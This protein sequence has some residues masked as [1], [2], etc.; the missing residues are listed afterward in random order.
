MAIR[1]KTKRRLIILL[2]ALFLIVGAGATFYYVRIG[3]RRAEAEQQRMKG[4]AAVEAGDYRTG[5]DLLGR[6]IGFTGGQDPQVLYLYAKARREVPMDQG[7][8]IFDAIGVLQRLRVME[9]DNEQAQRDLLELYGMVGYNTEAIELAD[10]LLQEYPNDPDALHAKA[11]AL[12]RQRQF[13]KALPLAQRFNELKPEDLEGQLL[14]INIMRSLEQPDEQIIEHARQLLQSHP[15]HPHFELVAG[16]AFQAVDQLQQAIRHYKNAA[17]YDH[18]G[19]DMVVWLV[20]RL[21]SVGL[22]VESRDLLAQYAPETENAILRHAWARR[23]WESRQVSDLVDYLAALDPQDKG[24]NAELIALR[25]LGHIRLDQKDAADRDIDALA[26]REK[27]DHARAWAMVLAQMLTPDEV[28]PQ[29]RVETRH[30]AAT[31]ASG[32]PYLQYFLGEA[33]ARIGERELAMDRWIQASQHSPGWPLPLIRAAEMMIT[34]GQPRNAVPLVRAALNRAPNDVVVASAAA[35]A[36]AATLAPEDETGRESILDLISQIQEAVPGEPRTLP[37]KVAL[38]AGAGQTDQARQVLDEALAADHPY[39]QSTLLRLADL[40]RRHDL[41]MEKQ[42]LAAAQEKHGSTAQLAFTRARELF[43]QGKPSEGLTSLRQARQAS[44]SPDKIDWLAAEAQYLELIG[45]PRATQAWVALGDQAPRNVNAQRAVLASNAAWQ[46]RQ[47]IDRSI[48]RLHELLGEE[49][50]TWRVAR[51]RWLISSDSEDADIARA[52]DLLNEV[53]NSSP[54]LTEPRLL[55]A[56]AHERRGNLSSAIEQLM[57]VMES[58][59]NPSRQLLLQLA[60]LRQQQGEYDQA[61]Q[62]IQQVAGDPQA[63]EADLHATALLLAQQGQPAAAIELL[64]QAPDNQND[65]HAMELLLAR[66]YMQSSQFDKAEQL[67]QRLL[68]EAPTMGVIEFAAD[69]YARH[70]ETDKAEALLDRLGELPDIAPATAALVR[71]GYYA[72]REQPDAAIEHYHQATQLDPSESRAW[73]SLISQYVEAGRLQD[74]LSTLDAAQQA[75]PDDPALQR[76]QTHRELISATVEKPSARPLVQSLITTPEHTAIAVEALSR[77]RDAF[78][79]EE[80]QDLARTTIV[81]LRR[82][83]DRQPRYMPLQFLVTRLYLATNQTAAAAEVAVRTM[84]TFPASSEAAWL[85]VEALAAAEQWSEAA[86]IAGKWRDRTPGGYEAAD[87]LI[88]EAQIQ[89]GRPE[90]AAEML[91]SYLDIALEQPQERAVVIINYTRALI[92]DNRPEEARQVLQPLLPNDPS[93]RGLW[94]RYAMTS[95]SD[96]DQAAGWLEHVATV[97]PAD[98]MQE[99]VTLAQ[100]WRALDERF[101]RP[102]YTAQARTMLRTVAAD[103]DAPADAVMT[104]ALI[105]DALGDPAAAEEGYRRTLAK[106]PDVPLAL[107]NLAMILS[108]REDHL[109]EA[110]AL[111]DRAVELS[112]RVAAFRDTLA[113]ILVKRGQYDRA[114][115]HLEAAINLQPSEPTWRLSLIDALVAAGRGEDARQA[116]RQLRLSLPAETRLPQGLRDRLQAIEQEIDALAP[117]ASGVSRSE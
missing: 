29:Q 86:N 112:P 20:D 38:L 83:A 22:Y 35:E 104:L 89:L 106:D 111:A 63:T 30:Q 31:L 90:V 99:Q 39:T 18:L 54:G 113:V 9:P 42:I 58:T 103:P 16:Y 96:P 50:P 3:Q 75:L 26:A 52:V 51:A 73:L 10:N 76:L 28:E 81:E 71:G 7:R 93:W 64:E 68:D 11:L 12:S 82:L 85:A 110:A 24:I 57:L 46:D 94:M 6:Y 53:V 5:A 117:P 84:H 92:A 32:S 44:E 23:L 65:D 56:T 25:A 55:L 67:C 88:A 17:S 116:L 60:R 62:L 2:A 40:S 100:A 114:I 102:Q 48:D 101:N 87:M 27:N 105:D 41:G 8:H 98:A 33:Y 4:I 43:R 72:R 66:L 109:E 59:E 1:A 79:D 45:D 37:I 107:N 15:D 47:F 115:E 61:S 95:L 19:D 69:M 13:E 97:I 108:N 14:T 74:M 49:S 78:G 34:T 77:L 21:A 91:A 36:L 80:N 70:G